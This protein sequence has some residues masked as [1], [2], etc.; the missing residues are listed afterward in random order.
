MPYLPSNRALLHRFRVGETAAL[1]ELYM[2][3]APG[4]ARVLRA[5]FAEPGKPRL[6]YGGL[7]LE[8][9]DAVQETFARAFSEQN[10]R[11]YDGLSPFGAWLT[12]IAHHLAVDHFRKR[13]TADALLQSR[14]TADEMAA[15]PVLGPDVA[16]EE[17][18]AGRL[19]TIFRA[20]LEAGERELF[21]ARYEARLTQQQAADSLG[22]TR[23]QVRRA[24]LKLR[25]R[26]LE[27]LKRN[28]FLEDARLT[29]WGVERLGAPVPGKRSGT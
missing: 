7:P 9:A 1:Q 18:E 22:L 27:H 26:L 29:G 15:S 10:R 28:G 8:L 3:Y 19:L 20:A 2:H 23:I 17:N 5:G 6:P 14:V 4:L 24:E 13:Q 12:G 11:A 21:E 16:A 25:Q